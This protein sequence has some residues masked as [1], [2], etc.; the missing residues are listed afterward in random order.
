[1]PRL[2]CHA[3]FFWVFFFPP[4]R[5]TA[6]TIMGEKEEKEKE[7]EE[8]EEVRDAGRRDEGEKYLE[9]REERR[10]IWKRRR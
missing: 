6:R 3:W 5:L 2:G 9:E 1:M 7:E 8:E 10:E 4:F